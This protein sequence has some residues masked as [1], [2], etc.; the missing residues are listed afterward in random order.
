MVGNEDN[1]DARPMSPVRIRDLHRGKIIKDDDNAV[2]LS[3][4]STRCRPIQTVLRRHGVVAVVCH[5]PT[6]LSAIGRSPR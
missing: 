5:R 2:N 4:E 6:P 1:G 3:G